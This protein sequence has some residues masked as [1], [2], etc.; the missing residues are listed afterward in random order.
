[1]S[2]GPSRPND[3][4]TT[5]RSAF[6]PSP[7]PDLIEPVVGYRQWR[8]GD[9]LLRSMFAHAAWVG[10]ELT[11]ICKLGDHDPAII[12]AKGCSC[13]IHAYYAPCPRTASVGTADLIGGAVVLR[14]TIELHATGMRGEHARIVALELPFSRGHKRRRV[15][16]I[17]ARMHVPVVPHR[18]LR[19]VAAEHGSPLQRGLRPPRAWETADPDPSPGAR[20]VA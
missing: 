18:E 8:L 4:H 17:G 6:G 5:S 10:A 9:E 15:M 7:A 12:P 20:L 19:F 13:G 1:M 3:D 2:A 14:G 11:A 16:E